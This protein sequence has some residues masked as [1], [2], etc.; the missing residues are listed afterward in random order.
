MSGIF[1]LPGQERAS[2]ENLAYLLEGPV[3]ENG[4]PGIGENVIP[5]Y[6]GIYS[7]NGNRLNVYYTTEEIIVFSEWKTIEKDGFRFYL[8]SN[9]TICYINQ[10]K[11]TLFIE[12]ENFSDIYY[13]FSAQLT[14][15]MLFFAKTEDFFKLSSFPAI[16]NINR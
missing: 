8:G 4:V 12:Y 1:L 7:L 3:R 13:D 10:G 16:I 6:K 14:K 2:D 11:W 9:N 5:C 15:K